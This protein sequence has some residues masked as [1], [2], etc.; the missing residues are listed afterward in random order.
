MIR[1][2]LGAFLLGLFII[3]ILWQGSGF[4]LAQTEV[5][6]LQAEIETRN[7]RLSAIEAEIAEF[8]SA[9]KE[10]GAE[11]STLQS[12]I[13]KLN[14]E[15]KKISADINYTT[16]KITNT[17]L[18]I[19]KLTLEIN[20]TE[21]DINKNENAVAE[22]I[23]SLNANDNDSMIEVFL[24]HQNLAE[25]WDEIESLDSVKRGMMER[26]DQLTTLKQDLE[27]KQIEEKEKRGELTTLSRQYQ[28]QQQVLESN[29]AEKSTLLTETRNE[30]AEYQEMLATRKAAREQ[31]I[32][33]VQ[34]IESQL[35]FILD[36]NTIPSPG[37]PVFRWPLDSVIQTQSFGYT[38][39]A[40]ANP[41]VYKNNMHNGIDLGAPV[42]TKIYAPMSGTIR[43]TGNTDAVPG[44]YS[45]GKW[46][47][48]DHPNGLSTLFAHL[49]HIDVTPGQQV[50]T[51]EVVGYTGNTG[52]STGPHLHYTLYVSAAVQVKQFNQFKAVT[53]CGAALS[54]F[55]AVEGYLNPRDYLPSL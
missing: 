34:D 32:K 5:E 47:L 37:T 2:R 8:E 52:Y 12:A 38:K 1:Q 36:P 53:G 16:N 49:S 42:G 40:L 54:P 33:E 14:L 22:I 24:R 46:M 39:F 19:N 21:D 4:A 25:F 29:K 30:E 9:L 13:N 48:I 15:H 23:R 18:E 43:N 7:A 11:K 28:G 6:R 17:D 55:S 45:W 50:A 35:Q 51:G 10:V 26:V 20:R 31:L 44:C 27:I 3:P 41:G